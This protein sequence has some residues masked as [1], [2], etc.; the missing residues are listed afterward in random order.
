MNECCFSDNGQRF[1]CVQKQ[2][3]DTSNI[4]CLITGILQLA[5]EYRLCADSLV[6]KKW[7]VL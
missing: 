5:S 2:I 7:C 3:P 6:L 4:K 1:I